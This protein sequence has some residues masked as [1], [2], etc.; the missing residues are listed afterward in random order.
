MICNIDI[1]NFEMILNL[2]PKLMREKKYL[3]NK[4][5]IANFGV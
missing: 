5:I 3:F 4:N 2:D 1:I